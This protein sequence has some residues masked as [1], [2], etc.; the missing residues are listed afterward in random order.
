M[1][2][3]GIIGKTSPS[4]Q[5]EPAPPV[6][7]FHLDAAENNG[8]SGSRTWVPTTPPLPHWQTHIIN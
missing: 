8:E 6:F 5:D 7:V 3:N 2:D 1:H 4:I